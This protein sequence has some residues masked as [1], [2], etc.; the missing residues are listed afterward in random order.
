MWMWIVVAAGGA[1]GSMARHGVN[2][3]VFHTWPHF[4]FPAATMFVNATG[5]IVY[6]VLVGIL[7]GGVIPA[8]G[9]WRE[10]LFVGLLGG[11]T[12]FSTFSFD[13]MNLLK[14]GNAAAAVL[15][16]VAQV[17]VSVG[18]LYAGLVL[19]ERVVRGWR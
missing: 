17:V 18:G 1:I 13:T 7:A 14:T 2:R 6:G 5:S 12:T 9:Y 19:A 15:N 8:G 16:V 4:Q 10:F 11:Y 3:F